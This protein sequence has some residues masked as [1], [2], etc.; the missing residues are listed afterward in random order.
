MIVKNFS[1]YNCDE[2]VNEK[3]SLKSLKDDLKSALAELVKFDEDSVD[4][5]DLHDF[6]MGKKSLKQIFAEKDL[7]EEKPVLKNTLKK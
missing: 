7:K 1:E 2:E 6:M 3:I 4:F 5:A